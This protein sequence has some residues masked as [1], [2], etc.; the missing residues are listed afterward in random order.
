MRAEK[1]FV[2]LAAALICFLVLAS[3]CAEQTVSVVPAPA[4]LETATY[5][6][7]TS[8]QRS[9]KFKGS[10]ADDAGLKGGRTGNRVEMDFTR[11]IQTV[12]DKGGAAAKITIEKLRY[13]SYIKDSPTIQFDGTAADAENPLARLIGQSYTIEIDPN[14]QVTKLLDAAQARAAVEGSSPDHQA[15]ARLLEP[16][17]IKHLHSI[18][19]PPGRIDRLKVGDNWSSTKSFSYGMLGER[20][21]ERAYTVK[22]ISEI[23]GRRTAVVKMRGSAASETAQ[24]EAQLSDIPTQV[25]TYTGVMELDLAGGRVNRYNERLES[26][27]VVTDAQSGIE[28]VNEPDSFTMGITRVY[29]LVRTD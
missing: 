22:E 20:S 5:H 29:S 3:G 25:E 16:D 26:E 19:L 21:Y 4:R 15:A 18:P 10:L 11:Q 24:Q 17:M 27:W 8:S 13:Y 23:E 7:M 12:D 14:G 9:L 6:L 2:R 1:V 28:D